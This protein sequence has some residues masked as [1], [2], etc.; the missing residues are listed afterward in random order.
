MLTDI[1]ITKFQTL[2]KEEFG[3]EISREEAIEQATKLISLM[4]HV[5]KPM[6]RDDFDF[7]EKHRQKTKLDLVLKLNN[8]AAG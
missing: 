5:Y 4:S 8:E 7:I 2:F 6:T 3:R 1:D